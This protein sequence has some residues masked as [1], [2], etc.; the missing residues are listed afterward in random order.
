[1]PRVGACDLEV[2]AGERAV[3]EVSAEGHCSRAEARAHVSLDE[4]GPGAGHAIAAEFSEEDGGAGEGAG[5]AHG[6]DALV[7]DVLVEDH[8]GSARDG[9]EPPGQ[10]VDVPEDIV[11]ACRKGERSAVL[12]PAGKA[13]DGV[14]CDYRSAPGRIGEFASELDLGG[15]EGR[16]EGLDCLLYTS[17]SPRDS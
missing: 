16:A 17:P 14:S 11:E 12:H 1:M 2:E 3:A 5:G 15:E 8:G 13:E 9:D 4:D 7:G 6:D 10:V